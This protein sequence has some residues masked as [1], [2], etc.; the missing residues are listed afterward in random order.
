MKSSIR[1]KLFLLVYG[2]IL[3]FIAG[4]IL[5]NN[6]F[7]DN[8]YIKNRK[9]ALI[10]AFSQL[11]EVSTEDP[12]LVFKLQEVESDYN[13]NVQILKQT[14]EFGYEFVWNNFDNV[15]DIFNRIYGNMYSIPQ[16]ILGKIIFDF[17]Q[18]ELGSESSYATEVTLTS[19]L[20]YRAYLMDIQSEFTEDDMES[21][22]LGLCVAVEQDDGFDLYYVMTI[23]F[24]SITDSIKIFNSFTILVG[25]VFMIFSF[26]IMY[27]ISYSFTNPILQIN[28]IAEE[29][30][31]LDFSNKVT[32]TS[33]DEFGDLGESINQMSTQ[34]EAN[35]NNLQ[36][37]N[38]RL[39]KE[40]L[41]KTDID[42][43]RREFIASA[44]HEL[45]TPLSLIMG[46]T[47]ALKLSDLDQ[48][49]KD[50]YIAIILDETNKMNKLVMELLRLSQL[51]SGNIETEFTDFNVK[52]LL[53][54][55]ATLFNLVFKERNLNI[56]FDMIDH[57]VNSDFKQLQSVLTNFINNAINHVDDKKSIKL[58]IKLIENNN[59]RVS[60]YNSGPNISESEVKHIWESFYKVDKA[61]TRTYGGQGLGLSICRTVLDLLGYDYG[62]NNLV[63]GIEF[64]FDIYYTE[65][66]D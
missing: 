56:E 54:E 21:Q 2:I 27:F 47:E 26:F 14:E 63:D 1:S 20:E 55:S 10:E 64:Y 58:S 30:A 44:S 36:K 24:Q 19:D 32:I 8:Y 40:I 16:G 13:L 18:Q 66:K 57:V 43:M 3:A 29:I 31:G 25:F 6:S 33:D 28:K 5:L 45:K 11:S 60:V 12:D 35:I 53:K 42:K 38:N 65:P 50:E 34:L 41:H 9:L 59:V 52:D 46:Y 23:T 4:L 39:A 37:T 62:V 15:P 49:S 61:R 22:M 51:E 48:K 17:N 7:L